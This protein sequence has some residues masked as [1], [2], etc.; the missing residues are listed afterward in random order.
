MQV[1]TWTAEVVPSLVPEFV[2]KH[3]TVDFDPIK[4]KEVYIF[5][6]DNNHKLFANC[7]TDINKRAKAK[8]LMLELGFSKLEY[9]ST[10]DMPDEWWNC[11]CHTDLN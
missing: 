1:Q 7:K 5:S 6:V 11:E 2:S 8:K 9:L 3:I 10:D 4:R